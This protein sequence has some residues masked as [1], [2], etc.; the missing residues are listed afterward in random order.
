MT[1]HFNGLSPAEAERIALLMEEAGEV[2]QACG[3]ILRHGFESHHPSTGTNN[4]QELQKEIGDFRAAATLMHDAGDIADCTVAGFEQIKL[5]N[6]TQY[7]H[8]QNNE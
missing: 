8:H 1:N 5:Q 2:I 4:R 7:L 3:K 6:V